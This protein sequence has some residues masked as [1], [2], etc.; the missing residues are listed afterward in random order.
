MTTSQQLEQHSQILLLRVARGVSGPALD[1]LVDNV[2]QAL[3][4]SFANGDQNKIAGTDQLLT[5]KLHV[6]NAL[7]K[8]HMIEVDPPA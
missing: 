5:T 3:S 6:L 7:D 4:E 2:S 1:Q 8:G